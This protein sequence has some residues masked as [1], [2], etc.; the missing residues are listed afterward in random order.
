MKA[1]QRITRSRI[2]LQRANSFW[3]YLSLYLKFR[4]IEKGKMLC[5]SMGVD[6]E[7]NVY[8]V[9]DFIDKLNDNELMGVIAHELGHLI[10]L[11]A[12]RQ[13]SRDKDGFNVA[14]DIAINSLLGR[15]NFTLPK[16]VLMPN[17]EDKIETGFNTIEKCSEKTAEQIYDELPKIK[18]QIG[19]YMSSSNGKKQKGQ[20]KKL[21]KVLDEHI[22]INGKGEGEGKN[23]KKKEGEGIGRKLTPNERREIEKEWQNR[24][25]EAHTIAK[26]KGD[27][28]SGIDRLVGHLHDEKINWR[29]LLQRYITNQIPYN[30]CVDKDTLVKTNGGDKKITDLKIGDK[31][32]GYKN[33]KL[34]ESKIL[35]KFSSKIK[36]KYVIYTKGGK[37]LICSENHKI[38]TKDGYIR[39]KDLNIGDVCVTI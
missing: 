8:Y 1:E 31:V 28:P 9:E 2:Q 15:N 5:D 23:G 30:Y 16:D 36:Q 20:G 27:V 19:Y 38:L 21:G 11:T 33:G 3:A 4:E 25:V 24:I 18:V 6:I 32:V 17:H 35:N 12:L 34:V 10:Y 14:S 37:R 26:M 13:G 22:Q 7:G 29:V 39:A